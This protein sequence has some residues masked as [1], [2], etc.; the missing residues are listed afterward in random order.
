MLK[1]Y[2][3]K[4]WVAFHIFSAKNIRILYIESAKTVNEI[5]F[6]EL[7]KLTTLSTT[8]PR[9]FFL[10]HCSLCHMAVIVRIPVLHQT[11]DYRCRCRYP[12]MPQPRTTSVPRHQKNERYLDCLSYTW[13]HWKRGPFGTHIRTMPYI[14][15]YPAPIPHPHPRAEGPPWNGR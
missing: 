13:Q 14:G 5:T 7:V 3:E 12:K 11:A 1:F 4:M 2:A 8:G 9:F 15:S 10:F 6:N